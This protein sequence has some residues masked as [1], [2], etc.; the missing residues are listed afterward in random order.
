MKGVAD[1][2]GRTG[3]P[4]EARRS[5]RAT[6]I[7][8]ETYT[9]RRIALSEA[10]EGHPLLVYGHRA[11]PRNF[12]ANTYRFRQ[13]STFLYLCGVSLPG[14]ALRVEEGGRSTLFAPEPQPGDALWH[15]E[16]PGFDSL[17]FTSGV[18][19]VRPVSEL[20][21][22]GCLVLPVA[23]PTVATGPTSEALVRAVVGQ[24]LR[25]DAAEISAMKN[26]IRVT[27]EAQTWAMKI[28]R[29]G[30]YD[31]E[32]QAFIEFIFALRQMSPAYPSIVT[33]RGEVLHG[34]AEGAELL[35]GQLLLVDAGAE[36]PEG[37]AS[38]VTRTWP[39]SGSF[40][41]RQ[42]AVYDAV[43]GAQKEATSILRPG[44]RYRDVHLAS[45]RVLTRFLVDEGL[46]RGDIDGLVESG[47]HA[48]F[49]PHGV[50][51]LI[52]LDV[53]DMELYGDVVG[54]PEGRR[55]DSQF[56]LSFLR[57]DREMEPGVVVTV[58]PGLYF[59]PAIL[60][61]T[62][63]QDRLGDRVDWELAR[64]WLPFGGIRIEDDVL[65]TEEGHEV[66]SGFITKE[67]DAL[68]SVVGTEEMPGYLLGSDV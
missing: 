64:S 33:P 43:L 29:P 61:D 63:L 31:D 53:H 16:Q 57:L 8:S 49:Y 20:D 18:D 44:V 52:G 9:A 37:Y 4:P 34:H 7:P 39:V 35:D 51:H 12:A 22:E 25:R 6:S 2:P 41:P 28:T 68:E 15:G 65:V 5:G 66:L 21:R 67:A 13:D 48:A 26:A 60:E 40:T 24:R 36:S 38:D 47:A 50:G 56:G 1:R 45:A 58:E 17:A 23:D 3:A 55:R 46:L 32:V 11:L 14:C 54:Y 30:V 59:V 10:V 62:D 42:R 19:A 27:C